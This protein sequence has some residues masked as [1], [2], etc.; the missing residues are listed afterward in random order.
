MKIRICKL[1]LITNNGHRKKT[2]IC[3]HLHAVSTWVNMEKGNYYFC[4][5]NYSEAYDIKHLLFAS[6]EDKNLHGKV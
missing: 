4:I 1:I 5:D 2:L 3:S 6:Y